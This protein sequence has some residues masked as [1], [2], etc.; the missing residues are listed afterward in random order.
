MSL[1]SDC[2]IDLVFTFGSIIKEPLVFGAKVQRAGEL[3]ILVFHSAIK[4]QLV[5]G[6]NVQWLARLISECGLDRG[7]VAKV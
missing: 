2:G 1:T 5:F 4:E 3:D 6:A 7:L